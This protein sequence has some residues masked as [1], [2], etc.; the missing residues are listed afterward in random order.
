MN[1][2]VSIWKFATVSHLVAGVFVIVNC[3]EPFWIEQD[4]SK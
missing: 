4:K 3:S 1:F 2:R